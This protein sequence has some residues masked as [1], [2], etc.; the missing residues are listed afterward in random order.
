MT[1]TKMELALPLAL[2][3]IFML[4]LSPTSAHQNLKFA[5]AK[6]EH[7][8]PTKDFEG[9]SNLL[10]YIV[11]VKN[12]ED[13]NS[14]QS[15]DLHSWYNSLLPDS[16]QNQQRITFSYSNVV[17]GFAVKLTPEEAKAL[18]EKE[19]IVSARLEKI[20]SL[21]TTRTPSFLGLQQGLGLWKDSNFGKGIIIGM[22]DTGI[23]PS[24]PSFS[25]EGM[26]LPPAK[27]K[28]HCELTG[29]RTCNNK[30]IGAKN[31]MKQSSL[32]LDD[33]G[34][35]T[36]TSSTAAGKFLQGASFF[37][38]AKGTAVGMAP[39]AHLAMYKVCGSFGCP[40]SAIISGLET[41]IEDGVDVLSLSLGGGGGGPEPYFDDPIAVAAFSAIQKGIFFSC[42]AGNEGPDNHSI[43]NEAAW[44]LT[45]GASTLDRKIIAT[46][47]LGNGEEFNGESVF[48]PKNFTPT[49]LPLVYAGANGNE[50]SSFCAPG[51]LGN[52]DVKGKVVLCLR[53][54]FVATEE[55]GKEV[56]NAGG[57]A[58]ILMNA[59]IEG[60]S[61]F[62][63]VHV[64]PATE[65]SYAAGLAIKDYI[66][67]TSTP[68][69]TIIFKGTVIGTP[70]APEVTFFSS[71][72]PSKT[73]PGLLKPDIIGPGMNIIAAWAESLDNNF[74]P[75][76]IISGTSMSCPH[77]SGVA[78]LVK[79]SH[80]DWSP[81]AIKSAM[82]T[83]AYALNRGGKP[84][85]DQRLL[86]ADVFAIGAGHVD[87]VKADDPG[88]VYD[89]EPNDYIPYLCGLGYTDKQIG[90]ITKQNVKCSEVKSIAEAQLNYPSFAI[91]FRSPD[92]QFYTRTLTNVGPTNLTYTVIIDAPLA[93]GMSISPTQITFT[94]V[95]QKVTYTVGFV[96]EDKEISGKPKFAQGSIKW[97][98][99]NYSASI[100]IS[101]HFE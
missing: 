84:I 7:H 58:L 64:L 87:P 52:V 59:P 30:L 62:A 78:A 81:A 32:P 13:D 55:I 68:T 46:A 48:Q 9:Q 25:D 85:V 75:F 99:E 56:K 31:F 29:K 65:V 93:V 24:H 49:L 94:E 14:L 33:S 43:S 51:S 73:S 86:P 90:I 47:K 8:L 91:R 35:G 74:P 26:P 37:G 45:V 76:N 50:S 54:E 22:L 23:D 27:W 2:G 80:P 38:N 63:D 34:H 60:Y 1:K 20:L 19:E 88:L 57:A 79:N 77:L 70:L 5:D 39:Y 11:H 3:L 10:T 101:V 95:K 21:H 18:E 36:H 42:S 100:P 66:N 69:A 17:N 98:S 44:I 41:A 6:D 4:S 72:G 15:K 71:R 61:T 82:M 67:S 12:P 97:V 92:P 53:S 28:G 40:E 89:I 83:T 16:T 96:P